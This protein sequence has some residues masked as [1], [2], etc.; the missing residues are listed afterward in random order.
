[1]SRQKLNVNQ[2]GMV[3]IITTM[4]LMM[5][6]SLIVL[7]FSQVMRRN[8]RQT[9]DTQLSS[10][11]FY[12]AES[13]LNLAKEKLAANSSYRSD[14]CA[15]A[16]GPSSSDYQLDGDNV[17]ITCLLVSGVKDLVFSDL[18]TDSK[19][20]LIDPAGEGAVGAMY[21]NWQASSLHGNINSCTGQALP[22]AASWN[23]SQ[24]VLRVDLVPL[25]DDGSINRNSLVN[26]QF[27]AFLYPDRNRNGITDVSWTSGSGSSKGAIIGAACIRGV[28]P[29]ER[30]DCTVK[31]T[32]ASAKRYAIRMM[33]LYLP[34]DVTVHVAGNPELLGAQVVAD[35]TGRAA[36]VLKRVQARIRLGSSIDVP[37]FALD[38]GN[39]LCKQYE[40]VAGNSIDG[41]LP[42][43]CRL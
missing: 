26:D 5:V 18:S 6:I 42:A 8:Q 20:A 35:S 32:G 21:I 9:L 25:A 29:N 14:N 38:S 15:D 23:C 10:Q 16:N 19:V 1:M 40:V 4:I 39:A 22:V 43:G 36:D 31:I 12:A 28:N 34:A 2:Q 11:A 41:T 37:D 17:K 30:H 7:G 27:T 24:P 3:A 33:G 13:G